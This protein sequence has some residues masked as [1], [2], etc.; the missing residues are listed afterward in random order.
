MEAGSN[1]KGLR[2]VGGGFSAGQ[3]SSANRIQIK[4][5]HRVTSNNAIKNVAKKWRVVS[6]KAFPFIRKNRHIIAIHR[7]PHTVLRRFAVQPRTAFSGA[8]C[9]KLSVDGYISSVKTA[10]SQKSPYIVRLA[11]LSATAGMILGSGF[12][13]STALII[14]AISSLRCLACGNPI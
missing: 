13:A 6:G 5:V 4:Y 8:P 1:F 9:L 2:R 10:F 14:A 12:S 7:K 3:S 11:G